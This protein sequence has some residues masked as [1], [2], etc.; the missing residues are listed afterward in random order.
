MI[1]CKRRPECV[2]GLRSV[3]GGKNERVI[4]KLRYIFIVETFGSSPLTRLSHFIKKGDKDKRS[5]NGSTIG[6]QLEQEQAEKA[7]SAMSYLL[8]KKTGSESIPHGI[9]SF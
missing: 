2:G 6:G 9:T 5:E 3:Y 8:F 7:C 1:N 4:H